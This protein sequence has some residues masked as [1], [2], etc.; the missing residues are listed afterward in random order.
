MTGRQCGIMNVPAKCRNTRRAL[1][2]QLDITERRLTMQ[3]TRI[4]KVEGCESVAAQKHPMCPKHRARL[5]RHGTTDGPVRRRCRVVGCERKHC[6]ND[7][8][9]FHYRRVQRYGVPDKPAQPDLRERLLAHIDVQEMGYV[10]PCWLSTYAIN[11]HTGYTGIRLDAPARKI[12]MTHRAAYELF[13]GPIPDGLHIDHLCRVRHCCNPEHL[14]PVTMLENF[15][16][17]REAVAREK[18]VHRMEDA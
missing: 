11:R 18:A 9:A 2:G 4:C 12:E 13:V 10:S 1:T 14:E 3:V 17:G 7:L 15:K 16:R 6:A 5:Y 8:C